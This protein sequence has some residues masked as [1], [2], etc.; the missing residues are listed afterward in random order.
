LLII[1]TVIFKY[2]KAIINNNMEKVIKISNN[3]NNVNKH[4]LKRLKEDV[5]DLK[6]SSISNAFSKKLSKKI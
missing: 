1:K 4:V 6:E 5:E 2:I 3:L